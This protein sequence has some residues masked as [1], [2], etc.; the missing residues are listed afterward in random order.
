VQ[1]NILR[2]SKALG[3]ETRFAI[4]R[5]IAAAESPLTVRDLV[6]KFGMHHSAIRIHLT[7]LEEADLI[8]SRTLR[9]PGVVGRPRL[10]YLPNPTVT[11]FTLPPRNY[12]LLARVAIEYA[13][14]GVNGVSA[15]ED[16]GTTWGQAYVRDSRI[17]YPLPLADA[18]PALVVEL[19]ALGGSPE[20][21][22]L[23]GDGY[24]LIEHNCLFGDVSKSHQP[25]VCLLHQ[26][27]ARGMLQELASEAFQWTSRSTL[28]A[29]ADHC[30]IDI[31]PTSPFAPAAHPDGEASF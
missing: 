3:E 9:H 15:P 8:V 16:F 29:G 27:L 17:G 11:T 7:R 18:L 20:L 21:L 24:A 22:D 10:V 1:P 23:D 14:A 12:E 6:E 2:L 30:H 25:V 19:R 4:F 28:A 26:G 31:Q 13:A 5:A